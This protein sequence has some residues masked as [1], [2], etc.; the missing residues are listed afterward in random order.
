MHQPTQQEPEAVLPAPSQ[1]TSQPSMQPAPKG[2]RNGYEKG[3]LYTWN[4]KE[5]EEVQRLDDVVKMPVTL[6]ANEAVKEVRNRVAKV[7]RSRPELSIVA[8]A[9]LLAAVSMPDLEAT[10]MRY[11]AQ[12]Y[13]LASSGEGQL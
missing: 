8:S 7:M 13:Q 12:L 2:Y 9:M 4:G 5:F 11:G 1:S 3:K 10:V 6:E